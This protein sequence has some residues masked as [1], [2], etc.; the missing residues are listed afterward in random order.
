MSYTNKEHHSS[1]VT[2]DEDAID[3]LDEQ[4]VKT[5]EVL[6]RKKVHQLGKVHRAIR[7][8]L[9]EASS[10][11]LL[12][13]KRP[14]NVAHFPNMFNVSVTGHVDAGEESI[15]T[16]KRELK[17]ELNMDPNQVKID[18]LFSI[19]CDII[20]DPNYIDRQ[21]NDVYL[22]WANFK[23][24][25]IQFD[26]KEISEVR[27]IHFSAFEHMLL[28]RKKE[29]SYAYLEECKRILPYIS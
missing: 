15:Q 21:F 6:S 12:V 8:Y 9:F 10:K 11:K 7:L 5:G 18:F 2:P 19:R 28:K 29:L 27:L 22:G 25:D 3:V 14:S 16:V 24:E 1:C 13:Q 4:G 20:L 26:P 17:E 23:L